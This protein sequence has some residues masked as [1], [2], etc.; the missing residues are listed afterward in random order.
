MDVL[1]DRKPDK[2]YSKLLHLLYSF[3]V[4]KA[5]PNQKRLFKK[6]LTEELGFPRALPMVELTAAR[7]HPRA[8]IT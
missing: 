2:M 3:P 5:I 6:N 4:T 1:S 7:A 8:L